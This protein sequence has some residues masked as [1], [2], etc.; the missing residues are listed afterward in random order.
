MAGQ[1][2]PL[3]EFNVVCTETRKPLSCKPGFQNDNSASISF[4]FETF[5]W[6]LFYSVHV[7][8]R[9]AIQRLW[10]CHLAFMTRSLN[11]LSWFLGFTS[12]A[13][14]AR[15]WPRRF[16]FLS[17]SS[18]WISFAAQRS[19]LKSTVF[20]IWSDWCVTLE[21]SPFHRTPSEPFIPDEAFPLRFHL[22][23]YQA[24]Y[25]SNAVT[26]RICTGN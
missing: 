1:T 17:I 18:I 21:V 15:K 16:P 3:S 7:S 20:M 19:H 8:I 14:T 23:C 25:V 11:L 26:A 9:W 4:H 10:H 24:S 6:M 12:R 13:C 5:L 2:L 22:Q